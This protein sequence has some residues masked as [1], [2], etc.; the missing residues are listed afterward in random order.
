MKIVLEQTQKL[1]DHLNSTNGTNE[2][3]EILKEYD[4]ESIRSVLFYTYNPFLTYGITSKKINKDVDVDISMIVE[5]LGDD[6]TLE[7][8][9][10][11][12]ANRQ[13]TGDRA[14]ALVQEMISD[15][16]DHKELILKIIDRD[17]E[18]RVGVKNYNKVFKK[19]IPSF[20]CALAKKYEDKFFNKMN[21]DKTV[22]TRKLD[23]LRCIMIAEEGKAKFYSRT[24]KQFT[25]LGKVAESINA[26]LEKNPDLANY[27]IDG[28]ICII[29]EDGNEDFKAISKVYNKKDY[30]IE[31]PKF[32]MFD[33][34]SKDHFVAGLGDEEYCD[35]LDKLKSVYEENEYLEVVESWSYSEGNLEIGNK[36]VEDKGW[37]GLML[38]DGV[39]EGK[40]T[41]HLLKLKKFTEAEFTIT[42]ASNAEFR[43]INSET[44]LEEKVEGLA[45][46]TID[47]GNGHSCESGSG[48]SQEQREYYVDKHEELIGSEVTIQ[49]F[50]ESENSK[51]EKSLRFPTIKVVHKGKRDN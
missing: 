31:N 6:Y 3:M 51:G 16:S 40:R 10:D 4:T 9:L 8:V 33:L 28:E 11:L 41:S 24:G 1:I 2:K 15:H 7:S 39:Y 19:C 47:L 32:K 43:V 14:I 49:Y 35:R 37:E 36:L 26:Q 22:I 29:D 44:G 18:T 13:V 34:I 48:F 25:T 21:A 38:R 27:V 23:G 45:N 12:F 5:E 46:I 17:L 30:T 20:D 50:E 42:G